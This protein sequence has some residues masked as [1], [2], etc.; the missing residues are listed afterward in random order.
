[1]VNAVSIS[2]SDVMLS[3]NN[4]IILQSEGEGV[5]KGQKIT[6]ILNV[7]PLATENKLIVLLA[8]DIS[9]CW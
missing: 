6:F 3:S 2:N 4:D 1:M 5:K 9:A 7:W 8:F